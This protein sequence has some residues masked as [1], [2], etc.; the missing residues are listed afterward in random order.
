MSMKSIMT[1]RFCLALGGALAIAAV[2]VAHHGGPVPSPEGDGVVFVYF[3]SLCAAPRDASNCREIPHPARPAFST[4]A[5]CSAY[6][7]VQLRREN[8]SRLMASCMKQ[9]EG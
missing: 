5:A 9:R 7:D 2:L 8:N 3:P 4:M 1:G 6:A